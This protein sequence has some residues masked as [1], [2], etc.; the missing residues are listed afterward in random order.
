MAPSF[1]SWRSFRR[2]VVFSVS[3]FSCNLSATHTRLK[4]HYQTT[5]NDTKG[6]HF[7]VRFFCNWG[8]FWGFHEH[9]SHKVYLQGKTSIGM[10]GSYPPKGG[11][12]LWKGVDIQE[13]AILY[14]DC[15]GLYPERRR[16]KH[17]NL[18]R[19]IRIRRPI[20][21]YVSRHSKQANILPARISTSPCTTSLQDSSFRDITTSPYITCLLISPD[22][23]LGS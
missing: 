22:L 7:L 13:S 17:S 11:R 21:K 10:T 14:K 9:R 5:H 8:Y 18:L 20:L 2:A 15:T 16:K 1:S 23:Y 19:E 6:F 12:S 4:T 3:L